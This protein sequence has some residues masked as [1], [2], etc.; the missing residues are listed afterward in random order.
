MRL[1]F[2]YFIFIYCLFNI[3]YGQCDCDKVLKGQFDEVISINESNMERYFKDYTTY[4]QESSQTTDEDSKFKFSFGSENIDFFANKDDRK[5]FHAE[6][7]QYYQRNKE[8]FLNQNGYNYFKSRIRSSAA[9]KAW[10]SC[11]RIRGWQTDI[12]N[13]HENIFN[14]S[15]TWLAPWGLDDKV[16]IEN[17]PYLINASINKN[18]IFKDGYKF[19][20]GERKTQT[21]K[22]DP[23]KTTSIVLNF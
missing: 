18:G 20:R 10:E 16:K 23:F 5:I 21:Y 22:R 17:D 3:A 15:L 11:M 13:A 7:S 2:K 6:M 4:L 14:L 1:Y 12:T 19:T 9:I 8:S